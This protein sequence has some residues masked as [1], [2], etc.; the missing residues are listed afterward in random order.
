M[1]I[2]YIYLYIFSDDSYWFVL[3]ALPMLLESLL[4]VQKENTNVLS[5]MLSC[6]LFHYCIFN[7]KALVV[8]VYPFEDRSPNVPILR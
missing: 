2:I 5:I 1:T 7:K 3:Y 4:F 8:Q 6:C